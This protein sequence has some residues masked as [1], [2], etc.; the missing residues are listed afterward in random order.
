MRCRGWIAKHPG[1]FLCFL[2]DAFALAKRHNARNFG[3]GRHSRRC[4]PRRRF[5]FRWRDSP[6]GYAVPLRARDQSCNDFGG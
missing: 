5:L 3:A 2:D 4:P 1:T 6:T